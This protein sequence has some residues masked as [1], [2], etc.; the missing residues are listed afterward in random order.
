MEIHKQIETKNMDNFH[1]QIL[2]NRNNIRE[3]NLTED[4]AIWNNIVGLDQSKAKLSFEN[5]K[6]KEGFLTLMLLLPLVLMLPIAVLTFVGN[7][8]IGSFLSREIYS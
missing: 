7:E 2:E 4:L 5:N 6:V 1:K 8:A 3:K